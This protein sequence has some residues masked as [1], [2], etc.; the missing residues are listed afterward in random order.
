[1]WAVRRVVLDSQFRRGLVAERRII[2]DSDH[3]TIARRLRLQFRTNHTSG[4]LY[5]GIHHEVRASRESNRANRHQAVSRRI[6][7]LDFCRMAWR[8]LTAGEEVHELRMNLDWT[9]C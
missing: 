7:E 2:E 5:P 6:H 4:L 3:A 8:V 1:M 9:R